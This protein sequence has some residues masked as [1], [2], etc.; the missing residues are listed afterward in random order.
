MSQNGVSGAT[1]S[2]TTS[3][4]SGVSSPL[5]TRDGSVSRDPSD[6]WSFVI[7]IAGHQSNMTGG[8]RI[9]TGA[10]IVAPD[11]NPDPS[12]YQFSPN[13]GFDN[14]QP[15]HALVLEQAI[16]PLL[17][18][19]GT[20]TENNVGPALTYAKGV[21]AL[22]P[23]KKV[24]IIPAGAGGTGLGQ[25]VTGQP[26]FESM[27]TAYNTFRTRYPNSVLHSIILSPME[28]EMANSVAPATAATS[29]ASVISSYRSLSGASSI[30]IYCG[31]AVPAYVD[32]NAAFPALLL[33]LA[34][35]AVTNPLVG[36]IGGL[37]GGSVG[38]DTVHYTN[39]ANRVRGGWLLNQITRTAT[40]NAAPAPQVTTIALAIEYLTFTS[41]GVPYYE[42]QWRAVGSGGAWTIVEWVPNQDNAPGQALSIFPVFG[43][44]AR[45]VRIVAKA[46]GGD[47][48]P[49]STVTYNLPTSP[50]P[51]RTVELSFNTASVDGSGFMIS[52]PSVGS[53][54][55]AWTPIATATS[56]AA[57]AI[58]RVAQN[59]LNIANISAANQR[60]RRT[61][62]VFPAGD[63]SIAVPF[64][65]PT[66]AGS[67]TLIGWGQ[68]STSGDI[69]I[70]LEN[71]VDIKMGHVNTTLQ[72]L[73]TNSPLTNGTGKWQ[74]LVFTYNRT[75]NTG[76]IYV[77]G[78]PMPTSGVITQRAASPSN[79]GGTDFFGI[80]ADT[81]S[82]GLVCKV[83]TLMHWAQVLTADE[84]GSLKTSLQT[85]YGL[86]FG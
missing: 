9:A 44:G 43:T 24:V 58:N 78:S 4:S 64:F 2:S 38:G 42:I 71:G 46:F 3:G 30:P 37:K 25:W 53:D 15:A 55:T 11:D 80:L 67:G 6:P 45:D 29:L 32:G 26:L 60:F 50:V 85:T 57:A 20:S 47:A 34:K 84:I 83:P 27:K 66:L 75:A 36:V 5:V 51:A 81:L 72:L 23:G 63:Y 22:N 59:A 68:A 10:T 54:A 79:S 65:Y 1:V 48:T 39:V 28:N 17:Y 18:P 33:V 62:Y 69:Y 8:Q 56:G 41:V 19:T 7:I 61:S 12:I 82:L 16:E 49:S 21:L 40:F 31:S 14:G 35:A 76:L 77:N 70:S 74:L 86:T 13:G 52:V 73:T